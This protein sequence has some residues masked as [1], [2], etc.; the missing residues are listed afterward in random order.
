M[1]RESHVNQLQDVVDS[2]QDEQ[3]NFWVDERQMSCAVP[4]PKI[5]RTESGLPVCNCKDCQ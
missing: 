2:E 5:R 3:D 1:E 4:E